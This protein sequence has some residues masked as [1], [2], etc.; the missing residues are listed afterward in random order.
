ML[1]VD[2]D[3]IGRR[4]RIQGDWEF[5]V[6]A[7]ERISTDPAK[8]TERTSRLAEGMLMRVAAAPRR[9]PNEPL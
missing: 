4:P 5:H 9:L 8:P 6:Q 7:G 1:S 2:G 3:V